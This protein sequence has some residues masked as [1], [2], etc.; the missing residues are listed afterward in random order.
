[1]LAIVSP[2]KYLNDRDAGL[3]YLK[4]RM[5]SHRKCSLRELG[6]HYLANF[7]GYLMWGS[8]LVRGADE[9]LARKA[10]GE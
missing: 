7:T 8:G 10:H 1:M 3:T 9:M 6:V 5:V 2:R 4:W